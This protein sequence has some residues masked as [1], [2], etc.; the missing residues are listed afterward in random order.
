MEENKNNHIDIDLDESVA[1]GIYSNLA[2]ITHTNS[3]FILDFIS[4]MPGMPKASVKSRII[5][6]PDH[7]KRLMYTLK[8]NISKYES[9]NGE[10]KN[11]DRNT[12]SLIPMNFGGPTAQA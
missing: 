2:V 11:T 4:I 1:E 3:E 12:D 5:L 6:T 9:V 8:E 10:I 7:A